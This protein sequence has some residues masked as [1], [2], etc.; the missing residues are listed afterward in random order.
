M[1]CSYHC[2]R[3]TVT[4]LKLNPVAGKD[5]GRFDMV[6]KRN[7]SPVMRT[8]S[9]VK[10]TV[11]PTQ[12]T[13]SPT[14]SP[15]KSTKSP[16]TPPSPPPST[17]PLDATQLFDSWSIPVHQEG[18]TPA[19]SGSGPC[20]GPPS[21]LTI[22]TGIDISGD[23]LRLEVSNSDIKKKDWNRIL[24]ALVKNKVIATKRLDYTLI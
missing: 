17:P 8:A 21:W 13:A 4:T 11:S 6:R 1:L 12:R 5:C 18:I 2:K 19:Y 7:V 10:R 20:Y 14:E 24:D 9:P 16:T 3:C 23:S 15:T 22:V